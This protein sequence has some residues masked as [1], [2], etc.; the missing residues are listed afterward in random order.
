[1]IYKGA[2]LAEVDNKGR[3]PLQIAIENEK[4]NIVDMLSYNANSDGISLLPPLTKSNKSFFNVSLFF[5]LHVCLEGLAFFTLLPCII[6]QINLDFQNYLM[7]YFYIFIFV[8][9]MLTFFVLIFSDPGY[10]LNKK[11]I[12]LLDLV[13]SKVKLNDY[14]PICVV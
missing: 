2:N 8:I 10:E 5:I 6:N 14:C 7:N 9:V 13:E 12:K 11:E 4:K 3:T 1:M